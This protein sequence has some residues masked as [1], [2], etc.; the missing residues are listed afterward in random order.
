MKAVI[1]GFGMLSLLLL[2]DWDMCGTV[3][4]RRAPDPRASG[5]NS[6]PSPRSWTA[7]VR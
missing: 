5:V 4:S 2:A 7:H 3:I 1:G 6:S